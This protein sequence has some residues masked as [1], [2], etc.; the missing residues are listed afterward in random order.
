MKIKDA[1]GKIIEIGSY[2]RY[3]G[4]GTIGKVTDLKIDESDEYSEW[5]KIEKPLLWYSN[6]VVEVIDEKKVKT[7]DSHIRK[8]DNVENLKNIGNELEDASL[9]SGGAEGGG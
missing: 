9:T 5:V 8:E 6:D 3:I 4:T 1:R 7:K 2:I